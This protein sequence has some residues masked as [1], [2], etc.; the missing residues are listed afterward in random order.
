MNNTGCSYNDT[1]G[2]YKFT[3]IGSLS[4][5]AF[6]N[7]KTPLFTGTLDNP[8]CSGSLCVGPGSKLDLSYQTQSSHPYCTG[9]L[10]K[11]TKNNCGTISCSS[12]SENG[13]GIVFYTS[14]GTCSVSG[15]ERLSADGGSV[16]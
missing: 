3:V 11:V 9:D 6:G 16:Y 5:Y 10:T 12:W 15:L 8:K 4:S 14:T 13:Y 2:M 1:A 7:C